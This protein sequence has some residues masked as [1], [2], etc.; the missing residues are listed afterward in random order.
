VGERVAAGETTVW[1]TVTEIAR[2]LG[3][4]VNTVRY[5]RDTY[6]DLLDAS[7]D[8]TG[9][10]T[11]SLTIFERLDALNR[12][13]AERSEIRAELERQTGEP[14]RRS[15]TLADVL[16]ELKAL[17]ETLRAIARHLGAEVGEQGDE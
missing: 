1:L 8:E 12:Q 15:V 6:R 2:R 7:V 9:H 17:H 3:R 4:P 10:A 5:W 11:Y 13:R 16:D 14:D